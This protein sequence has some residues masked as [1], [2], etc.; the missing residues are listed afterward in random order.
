MPGL[1]DAQEGVSP[2]YP[3]L[4][5]EG[6][7]EGHEEDP[8]VVALWQGQVDSWGLPSCPCAS[9][10]VRVEVGRSVSCLLPML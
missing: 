6:A 5:R 4:L 3:A 9:L 8:V 7:K 1:Y 10:C 2:S